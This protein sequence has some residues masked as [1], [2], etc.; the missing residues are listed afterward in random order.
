MAQSTIRSQN[1][2]NTRL[3]SAFGRSDVV[4]RGRR[5][6]LWTLSI[7][8]K[9]RGF[10]GISKNDGRRGTFE[11]DLQRYISVAGEVQ[12]TCSSE[13]L[14]GPGADFRRGAAFWS[15]TSSGFLR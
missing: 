9:T 4:S 11:E 5:K 1:V 8:N 10:C 15:I 14:G 13:L 2:Q 3:R 6:G 7:V 12:E